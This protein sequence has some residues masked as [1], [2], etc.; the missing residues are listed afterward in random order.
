MAQEPGF[1][2]DAG[3]LGLRDTAIFDGDTNVIAYTTTECAHHVIDLHTILLGTARFPQA[4]LFSNSISIPLVSG[5][6]VVYVS[7][8]TS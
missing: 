7:L 3:V 4:W 5:I 1:A 6:P 2:D 8:P